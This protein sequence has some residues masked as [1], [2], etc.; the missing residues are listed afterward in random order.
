MSA[1]CFV[2]TGCQQLGQAQGGLGER[3]RGWMVM[4]RTCATGGMANFRDGPGT[5]SAK[6][7]SSCSVRPS[8]WAYAGRLY[9]ATSVSIVTSTVAYAFLEMNPP[10]GRG[11]VDETEEKAGFGD[12]AGVVKAGGERAGRRDDEVDGLI[13]W[14]RADVVGAQGSSKHA[15]WASNP[16]GR[17]LQSN[18]SQCRGQIHASPPV[19]SGHPPDLQGF[20]AEAQASAFKT[21]LPT[22]QH[23]KDTRIFGL[24]VCWFVGC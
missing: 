19:D 3:G 17:G 6:S 7:I 15:Y 23:H 14:A 8:F 10:S 22:G 5:P 12:D 4:G 1:S 18:L 11:N 16:A 2:Y 21:H 13:V 24:N 9:L 20:K